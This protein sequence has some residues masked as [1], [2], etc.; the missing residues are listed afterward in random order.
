MKIIVAVAGLTLA[1]LTAPA[2]T[3][4]PDCMNYLWYSACHDHATD[5]WQ[6]CNFDGDGQCRDNPAPW[7]GGP[8]DA[9]R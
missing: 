9:I 2:A 1:L 4:D 3:A 7:P 8:F 5:K 6:I